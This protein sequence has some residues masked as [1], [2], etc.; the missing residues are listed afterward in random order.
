MQVTENDG[1]R[2]QEKING[3]PHVMPQQFDEFAHQHPAQECGKAQHPCVVTPSYCTGV[4]EIQ[5][6]EIPDKSPL[7]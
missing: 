4:I 5:K 1:H 7:Q 3:V 6:Q 2:Q